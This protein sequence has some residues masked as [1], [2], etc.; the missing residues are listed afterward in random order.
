MEE[1]EAASNQ[2][3]LSMLND[4]LTFP[5]KYTVHCRIYA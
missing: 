5:T 3:I 1:N 4:S 2:F